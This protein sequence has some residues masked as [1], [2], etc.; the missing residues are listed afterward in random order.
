MANMCA[1]RVTESC[2]VVTCTQPDQGAGHFAKTVAHLKQEAPDTLV[3]CL[4]PDFSGRE[5]LVLKVVNSGLDVFAHNVE[6]VERTTPNVRD[7][8]A[9][10]RQSLDVLEMARD[11]EHVIT[12]TSL[13]L[14]VGEHFCVARYN[15][16]ACCR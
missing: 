4:T 8:R 15:V 14:G 11:H 7:R 3:E 2:H 16:S 13:M 1:S 12:K 9:A 5:D 6:T 10:Y